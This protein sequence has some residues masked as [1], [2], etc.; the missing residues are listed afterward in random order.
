MRT[1]LV[2]GSQA[3]TAP[4]NLN[5]LPSAGRM[6]VL[7]RCVG[8][9]LCISHGVRRDTRLYLLLLGPPNPPKALYIRGD[10]V[11]YLGPDERNIAGL[12]RRALDDDA[13]DSWRMSTPGV[14]VARRDLAGLLD[15]LSIPVM[16]LH[17]AGVDIR[18][19]DVPGDCL[20]ALGDHGGLPPICR[21]V[22]ES[23]AEKTVALSPLSLQADQ[24]ITL[25]HN[26]LDR[27]QQ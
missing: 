11:R 17:E 22:V 15:E 16:Y 12:I 21:D 27:R 25:V 10:R 23:R 5:G 3:A 6:D 18:D 13:D 20:W 7:C 19:A 9:A 14:F 24:C 4:F 8:Q 26:E 1:F 2:V